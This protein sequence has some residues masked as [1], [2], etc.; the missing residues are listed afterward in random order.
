MK[1]GD[2]VGIDRLCAALARSRLVLRKP[3]EER[4][5]MTR[6][7]VGNHWSEEGTRNEVPLNL[8]AAYCGIVGRKL[9]A[10]NP[11]VMLSTARR[12]SKPVVRAMESWCNKEITRMNLQNTLQRVVLD[13]L[14][15]IGICKVGIATPADASLV[16]WGIGAG[17][18]FA[19]RVDLDDFVFDIHARDFDEAGFIGHRVRVPLRSVIDSNIYGKGKQDLTVS[20]DKLYNM[21]GDERI[22]VLGRTTMA[23]GDTE[24]FEDMVD[25]W[26][27]Y[28]PRHRLVIT[29]AD[30]Q[31]I[32]ALG[33]EVSRDRKFGK[34]LRIQRWLGP[35]RGPYHLLGFMPVP[36]NSM[37][38]A[39]CQDLLP[40]HEAINRQ[41]RKL[42]RQ[43]DRSKQVTAV[44]GGATEDGKRV[45]DASD[46]DGIRVDNPEKV[47]DLLF[48]QINQ[49]L[50]QLWGALREAF[51]W[52]AGN[53][54]IM[55]G[56]GPQSKTATQDEMLNANSSA[57]ISDMQ[58]KVVRLT[59][60]VLESLCWYWHHDPQR[61]MR[62]TQ[63]VEGFP[64][65]SRQQ[66][67]H[68][69]GRGGPGRLARDVAFE[70]M[71]VQID[72]YSLQHQTPQGRLTQ[73][74]QI[75]QSIIV[76]MMPLLQQAGV[77]F[78]V[79]AYLKKV[80]MYLNMPD[81]AD[82]L[83]IGEPPQMQSQG[84][85]GPPSPGMPAETTRNYVRRSNGGATTRGADLQRGNAMQPPGQNG[86][87]NG[88]MR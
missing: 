86:A 20:E 38:K 41:L 30:N 3:R 60:N 29:L 34:A 62:V 48:G 12:D 14:F 24:E 56:L 55:G 9:I 66:A 1:L 21:E 45:I 58:D 79:Q 13:G 36:G 74:N 17:E 64:E 32:G 11:R 61:I 68:P 33:N 71:D 5:W 42:I 43:A 85:A 25:L 37:P 47:R 27:V 16:G 82:I 72:P 69:A 2:D 49:N 73:I 51:S 15:S 67:V 80:G 50:F 88:A 40:L 63:S 44:Q 53:L 39:P 19:Q 76:P 83:T 10:N 28:L 22:S 70:D 81:L 65:F 35:S 52:M 6:Q 78:D 77:Q 87:T 31:V 57:T 7:Y 75:V 26:E 8:L 4:V 84:S 54:E 46:G 23:G 59:S 18:P